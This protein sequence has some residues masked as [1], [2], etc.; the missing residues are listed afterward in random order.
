CKLLHVSI[1]PVAYAL[2]RVFL[3]VLQYADEFFKKSPASRG[4]R[5]GEVSAP[6]KGGTYKRQQSDDSLFITPVREMSIGQRRK[7]FP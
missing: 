4:G 2:L 5:Q 1:L 3:L 6:K 7:Y